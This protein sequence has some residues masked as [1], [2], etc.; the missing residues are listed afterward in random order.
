MT[1]LKK[2]ERKGG[3]GSS[4]PDPA[5]GW[6][7][8]SEPR[9]LRLGGVGLCSPT[10]EAPRPGFLH[11]NPW[12]SPKQE[13][14]EELLVICAQSHLVCI[15]PAEPGGARFLGW[16]QG[17]HPLFAPPPQTLQSTPR[18]TSEIIIMCIASVVSD[19]F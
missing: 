1:T 14:G 6:D 9:A 8:S 11:L 7:G 18:P 16:G 17:R 3:M 5:G 10:T 12:K 13:L 15:P 2:K 4:F 19:S